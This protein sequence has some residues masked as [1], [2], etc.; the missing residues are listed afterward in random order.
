MDIQ[1]KDMKLILTI[2]GSVLTR[3]VEDLNGNSIWSN[4]GEYYDDTM[5]S[6]LLDDY[7]IQ[8]L[9]LPFWNIVQVEKNI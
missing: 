5:P 9:Q 3:T 7:E 8:M 6:T 1:L 2:S 4:G